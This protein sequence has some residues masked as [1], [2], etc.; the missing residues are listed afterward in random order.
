MTT[1]ALMLSGHGAKKRSSFSYARMP[2]LTKTIRKLD[3]LNVDRKT[4]VAVTVIAKTDCNS[5]VTSGAFH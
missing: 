2:S 3:E 1:R 4:F 5:V